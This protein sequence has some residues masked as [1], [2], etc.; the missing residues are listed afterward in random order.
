MAKL[1][2]AKLINVSGL[3][4]KMPACFIVETNGKRI[5]LDLGEGPEPGIYPDLSLV[6]HIDC[7]VLSHAHMDHANALHLRPLIGN[8]PVYAT[9]TTWSF[10]SH[11]PVEQADRHYLPDQGNCVIEGIDAKTGRCGHSPGGIWIHFP[12]HGGI[13]Y[14]GDWSVESN[15]LPFDAPP[16]A[17]ILLTDASYGDRDEA[18]EDQFSKIYEAAQHGAIL[19][20]PPHG[21]GPEMALAFLA[22]GHIPRLSPSIYVEIEQLLEHEALYDLSQKPVLKALLQQ[23]NYNQP[24]NIDDVIIT[25]EANAESGHSAEL[26]A[27][28]GDSANFIF[29]GHV[30]DNT[31]A[32]TMLANGT[33]QWFA[34]NVHPRLRDVITLADQTRARLVLPAFVAPQNAEKLFTILGDRLCCEKELRLP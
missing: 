30:P 24:F 22:H 3:G 12:S 16:A 19:C 6:G 28:F 4:G 1:N 5:M 17:D 23:Q 8:P 10:L 11:A 26:L 25:T 29:T 7:I 27:Q 18:L 31:P 14:T 15:L 9:S 2:E 20:V 33:A 13:T 34:W 32:K 21:R